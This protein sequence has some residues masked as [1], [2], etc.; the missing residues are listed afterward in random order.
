MVCHAHSRCLQVSKEPVARAAR[1][2]TPAYTAALTLSASR[3]SA[4][5]ATHAAGFLNLKGLPLAPQLHA[6]S[7]QQSS[8]RHTFARSG[9]L[10]MSRSEMSLQKWH[11][12]SAQEV[13]LRV[14]EGGAGRGQGAGGGR[15]VMGGRAQ[16]RQQ[17]QRPAA[18]ARHV[19]SSSS[20]IA[21]VA[22]CMHAPCMR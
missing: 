8:S 7:S 6:H 5:N 14:G 22:A 2:T 16:Q 17:P 21:A 13:D 18:V 20:G 4:A 10:Y 9:P 12:S 3:C 1:V 11:L 19:C 15:R